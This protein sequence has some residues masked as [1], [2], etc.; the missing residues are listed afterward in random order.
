MEYGYPA[1]AVQQ[2]PGTHFWRLVDGFDPD[3]GFW[4]I[5]AGSPGTTEVILRDCGGGERARGTLG[6]DLPL[7]LAGADG[8]IRLDRVEID[9]ELAMYVPS[10][11]LI[12]GETYPLAEP[13]WSAGRIASPEEIAAL[14]ACGPG[15]MI[16]TEAGDLPIDWLRPGDKVLTR[17]H[18]YQPLLW[19]DQHVL[20]RLAPDICRPVPV[21]AGMFGPE[22]P[23]WEVEAFL[24]DDS[25]T[26]LG[27]AA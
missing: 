17:D 13:D 8:V 19:L 22:R 4:R 5:E 16:A 7:L 23:P 6:A 9:G 3:T 15:T 27:L 11:A 26:I 18:G 25:G 12:P 24:T 20:P 1:N 2:D 14:P 10:D 21:L